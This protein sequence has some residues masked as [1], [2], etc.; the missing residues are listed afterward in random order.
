LTVPDPTG[1]E[2]DQRE[3][4]KHRDAGTRYEMTHSANHLDRRDH[5]GE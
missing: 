4:D 1:G 2:H 5:P 3:D